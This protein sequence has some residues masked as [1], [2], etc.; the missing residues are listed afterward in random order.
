[1]ATGIKI[2]E[3]EAGSHAKRIGLKPGDWILAVN[4]HAIIDELAL[5]FYLSESSIELDVRSP[6]YGKR[7]YKVDLSD[8]ADLGIRVE[9][10]RTR[11]CSNA[12]V[13]CFVD[14]LPPGV[15]PSLKVKDDDYRLSFLHGNYI[16]L[17]NLND[18]DLG[19]IAEQR[20]SPLYVSVHATDPDL[21]AR[22]LG[23][24]KADDL[25]SKLR[26]LVRGGIRIHAQIVLMPGINDGKH[27]QKT[28]FDLYDLY[29]GVQSVAIVPVGISDHGPCKARLAPVTREFSQALI[30]Q[31]LPWQ[32]QFRAEIAQTFACLADEF[33]L[34]G[35]V[36]IPAHDYYDDFA[37]IEDGIGMVRHF[38]DEFKIEMRRRRRLRPDLHGTIATG[39]LF[40]PVLKRCIEQL[41]RKFGTKLRVHEVENRFLGRA[42]TVAGLL[43]GKDIA[44]SLEG[45]AVGDFLIIP[46][47]ALARGSGILIDDWSP[48]EISRHIGKPVRTGGPTLSDFFNIL[49]NNSREAEKTAKR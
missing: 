18:A 10:F 6:E 42:I 5:K 30:H 15:R 21:R 19:R 39:Q 31:A 49:E 12:C 7:R 3:V 37:Q 2:L 8:P 17:T 41:N 35:G 38:L 24:K 4:G 14:Q 28:V 1:M 20:L 45:K 36:K 32:T 47:E 16:T 48:N 22:I 27:L 34:Q 25:A 46:G 33:Y 26:R 11:L 9:E 23:R 29:P 44:A 13:F 40:Y 43:G